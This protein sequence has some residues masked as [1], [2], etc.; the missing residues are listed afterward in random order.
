MS[1]WLAARP[2]S[3]YTQAILATLSA[4]E[5]SGLSS[6]DLNLHSN[7]GL[8]GEKTGPV[9][10]TKGFGSGPGLSPRLFSTG[11]PMRPHQREAEWFTRPMVH[12]WPGAFPRKSGCSVNIIQKERVALYHLLLQ[13]CHVHPDDLR[14]MQV[15]M[16]G[17]NKLVGRIQPRALQKPVTHELLIRLVDLQIQY[18]F[19]PSLKW[20]P[21]AAN[22]VAEAI[23]RPPSDTVMQLMPAAFRRV[24][25]AAAS[26]D[27]RPSAILLE[28]RLCVLEGRRHPR[29]R[30][31]RL[32]FSPPSVMAG[33]IVQ[34]NGACRDFGSG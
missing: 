27:R 32:F 4:P 26:N 3:L 34:H 7:A 29:S 16:D 24:Q 14:R 25:D 9:F 13:F 10:R 33:H 8:A 15:L 28:I 6:V 1:T 21:I 22:G 30:R 18:G 2:A 31:C 11:P 17:D 23:W 20:I 12:L 19:M 5:K